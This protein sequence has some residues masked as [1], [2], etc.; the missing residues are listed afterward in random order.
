[1]AVNGDDNRYGDQQDSP[2]GFGQN[3]SDLKNQLNDAKNVADAGNGAGETVK[4]GAEMANTAVPTTATVATTGAEVASSAAAGSAVGP[5]GTVVGAAWGLRHTIVKILGGIGIFFLAILCLLYSL[6]EV[7]Y[8]SVL[9]LDGG[10]N[11]ENLTIESNYMELSNAIQ[12]VIDKAYADAVEE[13]EKMI[14]NGKYDYEISL[15]N[16]KDNAKATANYDVA[17]ILATYSV[18]CGDDITVSKAD[19]V[20]KLEKRKKDFFPITSEV[21]REVTTVPTEYWTY[22]AQIIPVVTRKV[23]TGTI[24][25]MPQYQYHYHM[26]TVYYQDE[27]H[28]AEEPITVDR[29]REIVVETG[30]KQAGNLINVH[31]Y[32]CYE[33]DGTTIVSPTET[34]VEYLAV[35]IGSFDSSVLQKAFD[36]KPN[37]LYGDTNMTNAEVVEMKTDGLKSLLY[38]NYA[39]GSSV[40]VTDEELLKILDSLECNDTRK[41]LVQTGLSLVGKVPYFWGGK[42]AAGWNSEWG[43]PKLVTG[44]GSITTG[45]IQPYGLDCTGFTDWVYKTTLGITL[46]EPDKYR[47]VRNCHPIT[48]SE[49]KSGDLGFLMN[50]DGVTSNHAL[51]F[52]GYDENGKRVWVHCTSPDGVVV[53]TPYYDNQIKLYRPDNVTYGDE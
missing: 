8:S 4:T 33:K 37:E 26:K 51:M 31:T 7:V 9:G 42:S 32:V 17:N 38:G 41:S 21:K 35:T 10:N 53:N 50:S 34:E 6:P 44:S 20:K 23:Q 27:K 43:K 49:L 19:M 46:Y 52:V 5:V 40:P 14:K 45:T 12:E 30:T 2:S 16:L 25:G 18:M 39:S 24:D 29:Y 47:Q 15:L 13:A 28:I 36:Y 11:E 1:M 48:E 3:I 22:K